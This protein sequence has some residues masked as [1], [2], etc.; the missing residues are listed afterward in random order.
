M[1]NQQVEMSLR[2]LKNELGCFWAEIGCRN[3]FT[4]AF[5]HVVLQKSF[6]RFTIKQLILWYL[7]QESWRCVEIRTFWYL[8]SFGKKLSY[9]VSLWSKI[10][11]K[12]WLLSCGVSETGSFSSFSLIF[13]IKKILRLPF[14]M[15]FFVFLVLSLHIE[16]AF[17]S[18]TK[19]N[20]GNVI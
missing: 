4:W 14:P 13:W 5:W 9:F 6:K 17:K 10:W 11:G 8:F 16:M 20:N 19:Q 1:L 18:V 2:I 12:F 7:T 15:F 3:S